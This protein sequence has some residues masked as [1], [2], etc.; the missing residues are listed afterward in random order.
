[1]KIMPKYWHTMNIRSFLKYIN[2]K[3]VLH[4]QYSTDNTDSAFFINKKDTLRI[5]GYITQQAN[6]GLHLIEDLAVSRVILT[7]EGVEYLLTILHMK[8]EIPSEVIRIRGK[9][10][11]EN[12]P[13]LLKEL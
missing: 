12:L 11:F 5:G 3:I 13:M 2:G 1:M 9:E 4:K 6:S 7:K 10:I 8:E